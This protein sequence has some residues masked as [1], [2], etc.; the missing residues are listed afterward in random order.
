MAIFSPTVIDSARELQKIIDGEIVPQGTVLLTNQTYDVGPSKRPNGEYQSYDWQALSKVPYGVR[1]R[2]HE[3]PLLLG[4]YGVFNRLTF[5]PIGEHAA[6]RLDNSSRAVL[7]RCMFVSRKQNQRAGPEGRDGEQWNDFEREG[8]GIETTDQNIGED[9][10]GI[11]IEACLFQALRIGIH[12]QAPGIS[13]IGPKPR[14]KGTANWYVLRSDFD[15]CETAIQGARMIAWKIWGGYCGLARI[16]IDLHGRN[17]LIRDMKFERNGEWDI[18]YR[19]GSCHNRID[20]TI[21]DIAKVNLLAKDKTQ[22]NR[23]RILRQRAIWRPCFPPNG[24]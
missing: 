17:N 8:V 21:G 20:W 6:I 9:A 18:A 13:P 3:E 7:S 5:T 24:E 1:V 15:G 23:A 11:E 12:A 16:G 4:H 10:W 19:E 2:V 22:D 14:Q